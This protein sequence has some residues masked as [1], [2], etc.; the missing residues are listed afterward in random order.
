MGTTKVLTIV[1]LYLTF[2]IGVARAK[3]SVFILSRHDTPSKAQVYSIEGDGVV[4]QDEVD[5]SGYNQGYGAVANAVWP[6]KELM[7]V[8]YEDSDMVV[9]SSTKLFTTPG[10]LTTLK[11]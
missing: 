1:V 6:E 2:A 11:I 8:T 4:Y 3:E 10:G 9:W 5:I 7:F